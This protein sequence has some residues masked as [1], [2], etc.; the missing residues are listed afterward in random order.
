MVLLEVDRR[1][2]IDEYIFFICL[3]GHTKNMQE[4]AFKVEMGQYR[5]AD[6]D[7]TSIFV[8]PTYRS[9]LGYELYDLQIFILQF[10]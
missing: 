10:Q 3:H 7:T 2:A 5:I 4:D 6:I 1:Y 9:I 8:T